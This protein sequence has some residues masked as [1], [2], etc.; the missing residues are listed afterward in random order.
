MAVY[1]I[2]PKKDATLYEQ[3]PDMNTGLDQI[4]EVSSYYSLGDRYNSRYLIQFSTDEI[5][6]ILDNTVTGTWDAY[7]KAYAADTSGLTTDTELYFYT[8][9]G[10]WDMGTGR[11][12]DSPQVTNGCSWNFRTKSSA[13]T[14]A[15][16]GGDFYPS[17]V[18]SQS[19]SYSNPID[20]NVKVTDTI[21]SWYS[22]SSFNDGFLVKLTSSIENSTNLNIQPIFKNFS[23][24]TNTIYPPHLE[25][26]W[27]NYTFN[28]GSSPNTILNTFE[29]FISVYNNVGKYYP[30]SITKFRIAAIPKYPIRQFITS[31]Y[32]TENYYLPEGNS[33]YAIKDSS[34]NEYVIDFDPI[35]TRIS[36]DSISSYFDVYMNGLEPE[37]YYTILIKS[38]LDGVIKIWDENISFKV[39]NG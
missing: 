8:V 3:Y 15:T 33:F 21:H 14:W 36:A 11:F 2:F 22:G 1:K 32:Y 38:V 29:S 7:L 25:I 19:F 30:Q 28:T 6:N 10:S 12:L 18:Y 17:P 35:Y 39:V 24:D 31:S 27:D 5:Q 4:L 26:K 34:T 16:A 20:T 9:S 23:I 13:E 37:R